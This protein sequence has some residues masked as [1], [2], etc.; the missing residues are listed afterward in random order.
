MLE[1][2][3]KNLIQE[4]FN[5]ILK[6]LPN[7]KPRPTQRKMIAEVAN[8][9]ARAAQ[10]SQTGES[11]LVIEGPTGT[12]KSLAYLLPAIVM[13]QSR[14]KYLV[15]STA[16]IMLQEQLANKDIPILINQGE[17]KVKYAIAKG[18]G[19]YACTY[20]LKNLS[21]NSEQNAFA[22]DEHEAAMW[23]HKP[24]FE[25]IQLLKQM[26]QLL[27]QQQW[28]GDRDT[29]SEV[30]PDQLWQSVTNDRHGCLKNN[31]AYY[32]SCPFLKA[33]DALEEADVVIANHDLLL[34]DLAMGGGVLLPPPEE[35]FYCI[36]E[37]HNLA[38]KAIKQFAASHSLFATLSWLEKISGFN[39]RIAT[40]IKNN[41]ALKN[42]ADTATIISSNLRDVHIVLD[43]IPELRFKLLDNDESF[44]YR[45]KNTE[46]FAGLVTLQN[47]LATT[48]KA[49]VNHLNVL[50]DQLKQ[51]KAT[52]V[53]LAD[54]PLFDKALSDLGF[55]IGRAENLAS[56]WNLWSAHVTDGPPI[57]KWI[58]LQ[59]S[60]QNELE[61]IFYASP[62]RAT[63]LLSQK[64][65]QQ[66]AAAVLTSATLRSL[67]SFDLLLTETG[68]KDFSKTTCVALASPFNFNAQGKLIIPA[69]ESDPGNPS[70]HTQEI[71][72]LLP[73]YLP[74]EGGNGSLV[75]FTSKKQMQQVAL[76]LPE[77]LRSLILMQG[78]KSKA[79][80]LEMH[81]ARI[82][83]NQPSIL[84]GLA[85]FAEGLDLPGNACN[86]LI[87]AKLPFAVPDDPI[88]ETLSEWI[89]SRGGKP[90]FELTLP[91]TSIKLIQ[92]VG[93][94]I[95]CETDTGVVVIFDKRLETKSYGK[96]LKKSL[97]PFRQIKTEDFYVSSL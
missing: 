65:W 75:L 80:L 87:I 88:S 95:R 91:T 55:F 72:S 51:A 25:E 47:N 2:T 7:F 19:R 50:Q 18:R 17:L 15:I 77:T 4:C 48:T 53:N 54:T 57:A 94:L 74:I 46:I 20:R 82:N 44:V 49:L 52:S 14:D 69:M 70:A 63:Q 93:R 11:I 67:G 43:T 71:I 42:I 92:A 24:S 39:T 86:H 68:L 79:K 41:F 3:E 30:I 5:K 6:H 84:F 58:S 38:D 45:F 31:C 1:A 73:K 64:F 96:M 32:S 90:F 29:F 59:K 9:F 36:D 40:L 28:S 61:Y 78:D 83:N 37:A 22:F 21:G 56:V 12:G 62:V 8:T 34:A 89:E 60:K 10:Q 81:F 33:R 76:E 85:S 35:T 23:K 27:S 16:T 26:D 13:A 97:P 66:A